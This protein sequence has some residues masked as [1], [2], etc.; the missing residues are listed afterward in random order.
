MIVT[1][2]SDGS[3]WSRSQFPDATILEVRP[4]RSISRNEGFGGGLKDLLGFSADSIRSLMEQGY[5][6]TVKCVQPVKSALEVQRCLA[7]SEKEMLQ[8]FEE[9]PESSR[10]MQEAM[11]RLKNSCSASD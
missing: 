7:E 2:L 1:H 9:G 5:E 6:D 10:R 11:E 3:L 8:A 4:Q